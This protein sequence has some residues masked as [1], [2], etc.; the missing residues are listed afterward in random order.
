[1]G[2]LE[3]IIETEKVSMYSPKFDGEANN[4]FE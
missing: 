2:K 1:M 4:E 3:L